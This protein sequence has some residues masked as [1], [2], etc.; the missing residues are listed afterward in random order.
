[1]C[2]VAATGQTCSQG[3][4]SQCM[5]GHRLV[6]RPRGVVGVAAR[7]SGR[8]GSSASRG[9]R[10]PRSLPD[11]RDVVLGLAGDHA[12]VAAGAGVQVDGH[13]PLLALVAP[14]P[15]RAG[16]AAGGGPTCRTISGSSRYCAEGRL[17]DQRWPTR[18]LRS[19]DAERVDGVV[20]LGAWRGSGAYRSPVSPPPAPTSGAV[21]G[22]Q[23]VGVDADAVRP[24]GRPRSGRSR[25]PAATVARRLARAPRRPAAR[26]SRR[27][28]STATTSPCRHAELARP[29]PGRE[30]Q[31][32]VPGELGQRVGQ[33]LQPAVVG[34]AAV[35]D[36]RRP[37]TSTSSMP[38]VA[39][40]SGLGVRDHERVRRP[41]GRALATAR[42]RRCPPPRRRA[43]P[44]ASAPRSRRAGAMSRMVSRTMSYPP[45]RLVAEHGRQQLDRRCGRRR[46]ARSAA[47]RSVTVPSHARPS[48][49]ASR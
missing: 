48:P 34:E 31:R 49:H 28:R 20:V 25:A 22:A 36:L 24:P 47:A 30:Q 35:A 14:A 18:R 16:A 41:P 9:R 46:A 6:R 45:H 33:L 11:H 23:P 42:Q 27:P 3:A 21:A 7:S 44:A 39:A 29:W 38:S 12:G 40:G 32:V 26:R 43:A 15:S 13:A 1:M 10:A 19:S 8:R 5:A 17:A 2:T 37:A 4:F